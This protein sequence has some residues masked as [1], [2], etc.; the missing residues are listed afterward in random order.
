[1]SDRGQIY[2]FMTPAAPRPLVFY[3]RAT[4]LALLIFAA[5]A[6]TLSLLNFSNGSETFNVGTVQEMHRTGE[7]LIPTLQGKTRLAKPPL[8]A[9]LTAICVSDQTMTM[10]SSPDSTVRDMGFRRLA[11]E[12]RWL[13]LVVSCITLLL[14]A[15]LG[16]LVVSEECGIAA[17]IVAAT[18][19]LFLRFA[20]YS[21][22]DVL[23]MLFVAGVNVCLA[24]AVLRGRVWTGTIGTGLLL[25][26]GMM[27]KG[28]V[29]LIQTV[30][31]FGLWML[32]D[33]WHRKQAR[34]PGLGPLLTAIAIFFA[35]GLSWYAMIYLREPPA[36]SIWWQEITRKGAINGPPDAWYSYLSILALM[37]PWLLFL[38][39]G[40]AVSIRKRA[41][42][43]FLPIVLLVVPIVLMSL[44]KD[45]PE[46]YLLPM[47]PAASIMVGM[48][49]TL[50]RRIPLI[51]AGHWV[52]LGCSVIG[53]PI[54]T[55]LL[56]PPWTTPAVGGLVAIAGT[57]ALCTGLVA[58]RATPKALI[59]T[60]L[61]VMLGV[62]V[63]FVHDYRA[64]RNGQAELRPL[65]EVIATNYPTAKVWNGH[66]TGEL[67]PPELGV[68]LNRTLE[69]LPNHDPSTL[70]RTSEPQIVLLRQNAADPEPSLR[71]PWQFV[72]KAPRD[73]GWWWA[74]LL[75]REGN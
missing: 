41:E 13:M 74:F 27:S 14:A 18:S 36:V 65:A 28:P 40:A 22:T 64:T 62:Q 59:Y 25:G 37:L 11:W 53:F 51:V 29:V 72:G 19:L 8:A 3:V 12:T 21:S 17:M 44:V 24:H 52:I 43:A 70:S 45:K 20:R 54:A 7:W 61:L 1:M 31:P 69:E 60:T 39:V 48:G 63:F 6:P 26:L 35:I 50:V 38:F 23:L 56:D 55:I 34:W 49:L 66:P 57:L 67:P 46:R 75:P 2:F 15:E 32:W 4:L 5:I 30:V 9:W 58:Q 10:I 73:H 47:L 33:R 42:V 68:Y 16:R 71:E